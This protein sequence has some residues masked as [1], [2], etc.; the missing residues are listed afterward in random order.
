MSEKEFII[1]SA[2]SW[3]ENEISADTFTMNQLR[4]FYL[5]LRN[6]LR[7]L[8]GD[9]FIEERNKLIK[10]DPVKYMQFL[11]NDTGIEGF[12]IDTGF[13]NKEME[14]PA[15]LK[16]LFRIESIINDSIFQMPFDKALEYFEETL[17]GKIR[18]EGYTG[19][20]SIIAYRTGLKVNCDIE[21]ARRDFY[22]NETDWFGKVVK[23]FRDYLLCETLR[24]A[25]ELKVPVQIHTGAG[26]RDIKL[27]LS[28]PSY[29]TN[30][31][32][33]YE[34]KVIFVHAGYPYHRE[35]SWMSYL[36]P[37]VY[38][39]T[40]Q[41]IPFAPLAAYTILNEIFEVAPLNK[42]MHGSDAFH[43]PEIAWLAAKLAKKAIHKTTEMMIEK[44]I[45]DEKDAKELVER[46]LY[47]NS[48]EMYG[49]D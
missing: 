17:R 3:L 38:L 39:D 9:N 44:N 16:L 30:V 20:K 13:G 49:F 35:T 14:I 6:E 45:L 34:G 27:E 23:G 19:F 31:V 7:R 22:S 43:I 33:K 28:R 12:V 46:F 10:D 48:K 2:E 29:L 37:S 25:K 47:Y 15:K 24:I 36:Y 41:V 5:Y 26:D 11:F 32:R 21:Q 42:V 1:A 40:S 18:K 4:P 8:L